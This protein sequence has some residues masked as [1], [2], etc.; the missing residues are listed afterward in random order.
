MHM[1]AQVV[2]KLREFAAVEAQALFSAWRS[3]RGD[4]LLSQL[5]QDFSVEI[6]RL[7]GLF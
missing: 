6:N 4:H 7:S 3:R 2:E 1:F 5:S